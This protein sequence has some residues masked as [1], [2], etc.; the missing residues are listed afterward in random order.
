MIQYEQ[1][2]NLIWTS[3]WLCNSGKNV[4][5]LDSVINE[6]TGKNS[7]LRFEVAGSKGQNVLP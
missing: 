1:V 6:V 3:T 2:I 4:D 7:Y 5:D